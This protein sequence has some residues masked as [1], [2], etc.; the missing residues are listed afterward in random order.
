MEFINYRIYSDYS[1]GLSA[2]KVSDVVNHASDC[3]SAEDEIYA[4]A[5][6]DK[7]N[8]FASLEFSIAALKKGMQPMIGNV[9]RI[10]I[11]GLIVAQEEHADCMIIA[12]NQ[13]GLKN[14]I[15]CSSL[16]FMNQTEESN[17][18]YIT[19]KQLIEHKEGLI[20][21]FG[22]PNS[23]SEKLILNNKLAKNEELLL[24]FSKSFGNN[25]Y[26]EISRNNLQHENV[27][28][29]E[30]LRLAL[31]HNIPIVGTSEG[32]FPSKKH[33]NAHDALI[34]IVQ[35]RYIAEENRPKSNT[36]SYL[37]KNK[38]LCELF[39]D[40]PE[41]IENT[42]NIAKRCSAY[43]SEQSPLLPG[44]SDLKPG[45]TLS[46][47]LEEQATNG[48]KEHLSK[49]TYKI[50]K[51]K[52]FDRLGYELEVI[53]QMNY[54]GYFLIVSD[55]IR[56]SKENGIPVGPGR[57]SGAGSVVAWSLQITDL[58]PIRYNLIF[59]RFL[60]PERVSMP[61]FDI[62]FC[63]DRRDEVINYVKQKYGEDRVAQ[64]ITFG[65]LQ[66]RAVLRDVGRVL[67]IPYGLVDSICKMVPNNPAHPV[68]LSEAIALDRGL[69]NMAKEDPQIDKLLNIGLQ[70]EGVNRH[71]STHAAGIVIADRPLTELVPVYQDQNTTMPA[72]QYT[73]KYAEAA[74][75]VKFDFLGLKTL[76]VISWCCKEI[77]KSNPGFVL[78]SLEFDNEDTYTLLAS[79]KTTGVFQFEGAGMKEAIKKLKPDRFVDI[80]AL[81]SLY[82]PGPMDNI[83][84]F[85]NRKHGLEAPEYLHPI[86]ENILRETYGI[87]VYQEQVMQI[88]Q[89]MAGFTFGGADL[90]RR[91]MGKK[92]KAEMEA[93]RSRFVDGC[94][95]NK[96]ERKMADEI[97]ELVN[98]FASY[99]FNKS[100]AAA[101]AVLSYQTAYLKANHTIEFLVASINLEIGDTDKIN[102]FIQEA[103]DFKI[104][105]ILP[106]INISKSYFSIE[107]GSI[108]YGL[109]ALKSVGHKLV[110]DLLHERKR[111]GKFTDIYDLATRC[112]PFL[113]KRALESF[114]KAGA[115]NSIVENAREC[116]ENLDLILQEANF[117]AQQQAS[118]QQSL[119]G[120]SQGEEEARLITLNTYTDWG[121]TEKLNLEFEAI[122]FYLSNHP[123]SKY[124]TRLDNL[125][126]AFS[127]NVELYATKKGY[128]VM[129]AG[130]ITSKKIRSSKR[131]KFAFMQISD[132]YG[133][134]DVS[135]FDE[136]LI[137]NHNDQLFVGN[138][139]LFALDVKAEDAGTRVVITKIMDIDTGTSKINSM[140][141]AQ[142][143]SEAQYNTL[144]KYCIQE[145][146]EPSNAANVNSLIPLEV[147]LQLEGGT[148][149]IGGLKLML[150][151]DTASEL[152]LKEGIA[153]SEIAG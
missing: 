48:L 22:G 19:F 5:L 104:P 8:L 77:L 88:A 152:K 64:I 92:I 153:I 52:Y 27:M 79:G 51:Q 59:E 149:H 2:N 66:P 31:K 12:K 150:S 40:L 54:P 114:I 15:K 139:L 101:Y 78:P 146:S 67:Q 32:C 93:L 23:W 70:L 37:K 16:S 124:R 72:V 81:G 103:R 99:G 20:C 28:E 53:N 35:G 142:I 127:Q 125:H 136:Q 47:E 140:F 106:D 3:G 73:M 91:A 98:K 11:D 131:G 1:L 29:E 144:K 55:F 25:L 41:A 85:V 137:Y 126:V 120:E 134:L 9:L 38:E 6:C 74:G 117:K 56:W 71:V 122:G 62:D 95:Q 24:K 60:N 110:E 45:N 68:T 135:I 96:V 121:L 82:R 97:F 148:V 49:I 26:I 13:Q 30:L 43:M 128:K 83:P 111:D 86:L 4:A 18:P 44:Y 89:S 119:F 102:L 75:L 87:I 107:D 138:A 58:D 76:T 115:L 90:L 113:S 34:C 94:V 100:H 133:L 147:E 17:K 21:F 46:Q 42:K 123:I 129:V 80:Y 84:K 145:S 57:G 109:A 141:V 65:K 7:Y 63:Q 143:S 36:F 118:K 112:A 50:D 116:F 130:V 33:S 108:V 10:S 39:S 14:L 61:D 132:E 69:R 105:L 151:H